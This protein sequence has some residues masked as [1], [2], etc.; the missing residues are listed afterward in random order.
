MAATKSQRSQ[1]LADQLRALGVRGV[2][3]KMAEHGQLLA[4]R[5]EMPTCYCREGR[6]YFENRPKTTPFPDWAPNADH[7]PKLKMDDGH[8][9]P[10]NVRLAHVY[11][12]NMDDGWRKRIR[13]MV[14]KD[15]TLSF[16][17]IAEALNRKKKTIAPPGAKSWTARLARKAYVS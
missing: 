14:E 6:R 7:Y 16:K 3:V 8:L 10:W 15:P 2:L 17:A 12:N 9:D 13:R 11:C 5:C 4:L 1:D